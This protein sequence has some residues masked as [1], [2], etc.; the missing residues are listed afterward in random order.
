M[1]CTTAERK[2]MEASDAMEAK[3]NYYCSVVK[4]YDVD[5]KRL[6]QWKEHYMQ[7]LMDAAKKSQ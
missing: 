5:P 7:G 3:A 6:V 2:E 1:A 4:G